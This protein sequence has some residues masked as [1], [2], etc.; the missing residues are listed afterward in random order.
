[1]RD[2]MTVVDRWD[3]FMYLLSAQPRRQIVVSLMEAPEG[4]QLSLPEAAITP[5]VSVEAERDEIEL[6][7]RHLPLLA[8]AGYVRWTAEPFRVQRGPRFDEPAT[9]MRALLS[10]DDQLAPSLVSDC[11][12]ESK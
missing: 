7:H 1:M 8:D 3:Q 11:V 4:R 12:A 5:A 10:A 2:E 6:H 9:V